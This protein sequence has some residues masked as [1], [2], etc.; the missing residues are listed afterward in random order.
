MFVLKCQT[1]FSFIVFN[2]LFTNEISPFELFIW[3][4][5]I[6][7]ILY[8]LHDVVTSLPDRN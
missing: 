7:V 8:T 4:A 2:L 6:Q 5:F 1:A 3:A